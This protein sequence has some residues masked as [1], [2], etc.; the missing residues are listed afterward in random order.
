MQKGTQYIGK[1]VRFHR[2]K[3]GLSQEALASL[4]GVGKTTIFDIE[5]GK[6][7]IKLTTLLKVFEILNV[8]CSFQSPLMDLFYTEEELS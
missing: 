6:L 1:I 2:K 5:H 3:S 8:S 4:A 7:S